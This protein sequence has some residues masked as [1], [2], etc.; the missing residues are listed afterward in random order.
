[1]LT[2]DQFACARLLMVKGVDDPQTVS[3]IWTSARQYGGAHGTAMIERNRLSMSVWQQLASTLDMQTGKFSVVEIGPGPQMLFKEAMRPTSYLPIDQVA[4]DNTTIALDV[5]AATREDPQALLREARKH[6]GFAPAD[7]APLLL[8]VANVLPSIVDVPSM[9]A[10]LRRFD[11]PLFLVQEDYTERCRPPGA[12]A[13]AYCRPSCLTSSP[14]CDDHIRNVS[15]VNAVVEAAG[16]RFLR[17]AYLPNSPKGGCLFCTYYGSTFAVAGEA[18][19]PSKRSTADPPLEHRHSHSH[20]GGEHP[21]PPRPPPTPPPPHPHQLEDAHARRDGGDATEAPPIAHASWVLD[22]TRNGSRPTCPFELARLARGGGCDSSSYQR[23]HAHL[24]TR[25]GKVVMN[26]GLS[27]QPEF[28]G[29]LLLMLGDSLCRDQWVEMVC[30]LHGAEHTRVHLLDDFNF[31]SRDATTLLARVH[32]PGVAT[33]WVG[34]LHIDQMRSEHKGGHVVAAQARRLV[35]RVADEQASLPSAAHAAV[36]PGLSVALHLC[37]IKAHTLKS[38]GYTSNT[39]KAYFDDLAQFAGELQSATNASLLY[40]RPGP[41]THFATVDAGFV[42]TTGMPQPCR[43][44]AQTTAQKAWFVH[45]E[46]TMGQTFAA[47]SAGKATVLSGVWALSQ[48]A[49]AQHPGLT[50]QFHGTTNQSHKISDCLHYCIAGDGQVGVYE[51]F[52]RMWWW[53]LQADF[54]FHARGTATVQ[55]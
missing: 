31:T 53:H 34:F 43:P 3:N 42:P 15:T 36:R 45:E 25:A 7:D 33:T 44:I 41:A 23:W 2:M 13:P 26:E 27:L 20:G 18:R 30:A 46:E 52:N 19:V 12:L 8:I 29:T 39:P 38:K 50:L 48:D 1:M 9:F 11:A 35:A 16:F 49:W 10:W 55:S 6:K 47:N 22:A 37:S 28:D 4:W 54:R 14:N 40:Y 21:Q 17:Q 51:A 32:A 24:T 5:N